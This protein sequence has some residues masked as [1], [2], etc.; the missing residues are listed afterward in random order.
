MTQDACLR[1]D[2][3]LFGVR[4]EKVMVSQREA[5]PPGKGRSGQ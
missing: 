5:S 1:N 2:F 4:R 3:A